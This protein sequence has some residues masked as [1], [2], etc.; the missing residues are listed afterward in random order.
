MAGT[1]ERLFVAID[2]GEEVRRQ[3]SRVI[4]TLAASL[5]GATR[6]PKV[7]WVK[8]NA[9]HVTIKFL[10]EVDR[11]D[12]ERV[13]ALLSPPIAVAPFEIEW[14]GLGTFPNNRHPRALWV[15]V[16]NGAAS[17]ARVEAEVSRRLAGDKAFDLDDR[18]F[19]PHL[20]IGRVK[21]AGDGVDW[22]RLLQSV[23][24][25]Q[26]RSAVDRVTLYRSQLSQ[27]GPH[28]TG[29]VSAPLIAPPS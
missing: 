8:P 11:P 13:Q 12:I 2:I 19:L 23:E 7:A 27:F 24:I 15:G 18:A 29:L 28:Y 3:V 16:V 26:A 6:P 5:E 22:P 21:M 10:G 1:S 9:L 20:T 4:S 25:R 14:R 17:L